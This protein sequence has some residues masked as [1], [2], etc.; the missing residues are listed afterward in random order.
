MAA[1]FD[2]IVIGVGGFGSG[3]F[4][5]LARRGARVLGIER[6]GVAHDR[7]SSH[8]ETRVIRK[9]Y[10]EHPDYVPLLHRAYDL[11]AELEAESGRTLFHQCGLL[12]AGPPDGVTIQGAKFAAEKYGLDI[13]EL[14]PADLGDRVPG[15]RFPEGMVAVLESIAGYLE[16]ENCVRTHVE[17]GQAAG[18]VLHTGE[19]VTGWESD[20][21]TVRVTTDRDEYEAASL[22]V[23][24]GPWAAQLLSDLVVK[25]EVRRK[26]FLWCPVAND[27][28]DAARPSPAWFYELPGF[29]EFYAIPSID[30]QTV[31]A[32]EHTD[33]ALVADPL[34]IDRDL[35]PEDVERVAEF[36]KLSAPDVDPRPVR[37]SICMYTNSP[38][39]H[40][41]IDRLPGRENVVF[42]A[43]FSGHGFK[44]TGVLGQALAEMALDGKTDLPVGFLSRARFG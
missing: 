33:G 25:L 15:L 22:V 43:G 18:G 21:R 34:A 44:F 2:S 8:G 1:R 9:A 7:G 37:H 10:F 36:L 28:Y 40:F 29:G 35:H 3:A 16:V 26:P 38:D 23:T 17:R 14:E 42:G 31:K 30:G 5:H 11:W 41:L 6:F 32:A 13:E 4:Y 20:G 12:L 19:T 24:A 39:G 27:L